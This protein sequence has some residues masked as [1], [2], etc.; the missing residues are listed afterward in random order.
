M[1]LVELALFAT[2]GFADQREGISIYAWHGMNTEEFSALMKH[3]IIEILLVASH[4]DAFV[5]EED[6]NLSERLFGEYVGLDLR[7]VPRITRVSTGRDALE[8]L[9]RKYFDVVH[10]RSPAHTDWL[11]L[12]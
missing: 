9:Q 12:V 2:D 7:F 10:G 6:R 11:S 8:L 3:R 5:L 4:Y 1:S